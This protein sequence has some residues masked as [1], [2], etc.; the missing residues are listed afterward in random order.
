VKPFQTL[1]T[2]KQELLKLADEF[3]PRIAAWRKN[4]MRIE[5]LS[6]SQNSTEML[7]QKR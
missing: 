6:G 5:H 3:L 4:E 2:V 7:G 1:F